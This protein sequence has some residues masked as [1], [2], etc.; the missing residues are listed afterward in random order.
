MNAFASVQT[1]HRGEVTW[2]WTYGKL[3]DLDYHIKVNESVYKKIADLESKYNVRR[4]TRYCCQF[5][6]ALI[7]GENRESI[8]AATLSL[9]RYIARFSGVMPL[10]SR[11]R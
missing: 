8:E 7:E 3:H 2:W 4:D 5:E 9:A 10:S 11:T 1:V 6:G